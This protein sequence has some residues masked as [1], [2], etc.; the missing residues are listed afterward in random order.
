MYILFHI[1]SNYKKYIS[2]KRE[3]SSGFEHVFVGE[4]KFGREIMGLHNWVQIYLQEKQELLDYK[5]YK[6]RD[7]D[8]VLFSSIN[9][10]NVKK[11]IVLCA[12][13]AESVIVFP[14]CSLMKMTMS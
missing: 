9:L 3:D 4:T 12:D 8:A 11:Y 10:K 6:A 2:P 1:C 13:F 7:N 14:P 5:G